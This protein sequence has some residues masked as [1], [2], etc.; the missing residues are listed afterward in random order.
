[1]G[2][3][4]SGPVDPVPR[5]DAGGVLKEAFHRSQREVAF[6]VSPPVPGASPPPAGTS[7]AVPTTQRLLAIGRTSSLIL[8]KDEMTLKEMEERR[9]FSQESSLTLSQWTSVRNKT[10]LCGDPGLGGDGGVTGGLGPFG[11]VTFQGA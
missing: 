3:Y 6:T 5:P 7:G 11:R 4:V 10:R 2:G 1:M 9:Q 8:L